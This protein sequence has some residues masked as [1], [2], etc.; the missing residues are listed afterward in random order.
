M[1]RLPLL[2]IGL[3]LLTAPARAADDYNS[4]PIRSATRASRAAR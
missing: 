4:A 1:P 3:C 2:L